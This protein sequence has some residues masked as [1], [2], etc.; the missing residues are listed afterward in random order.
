MTIYGRRITDKDM[1]NIAS[2]MDDDIREDLH[3]DLAPCSNEEFINE[4]LKRDPEFMDLLKTEFEFKL[5][6][7]YEKI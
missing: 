7:K 2:Y 1:S 3:G 4:Y 5:G 6:G